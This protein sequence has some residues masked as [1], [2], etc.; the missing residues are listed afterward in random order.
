MVGSDDLWND[1]RRISGSGRSFK[2]NTAQVIAEYLKNIR[3]I[4]AKEH[5]ED[6]EIINFDESS[7]YMDS[8]G[9]HSVATKGA[10]KVYAR[11]TGKE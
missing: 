3:D 5:F 11:T 6:S 7:F 9:N 4:I 1:T 8:I 10:R 2:P